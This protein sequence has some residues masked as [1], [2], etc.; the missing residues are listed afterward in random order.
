MYREAYAPSAFISDDYSNLKS[1]YKHPIPLDLPEPVKFYRPQHPPQQTLYEF[2]KLVS[3]GQVFNRDDQLGHYNEQSLVAA[4]DNKNFLPSESVALP[5]EYRE[6]E[7]IV[8]GYSNANIRYKLIPLRKQTA[9][10]NEK[11]NYELYNSLHVPIHRSPYINQLT[12]QAQVNTFPLF[13]NQHSPQYQR[14]QSIPNVSY[15]NRNYTPRKQNL[16]NLKYI[17]APYSRSNV[18]HRKSLPINYAPT[19]AS[20]KKVE[21]IVQKNEDEE[22]ATKETQ[23]I[24]DSTSEKKS[25]G[26]DEGI[27]QDPTYHKHT[28]DFEES[29]HFDYKDPQDR[30]EEEYDEDNKR[31]STTHIPLRKHSNKHSKNDKS[32]VKNYYKFQN[33]NYKREHSKPKSNKSDTKTPKIIYKSINFAKETDETNED[34]I[35]GKHSENIPVTRKHRLFREKLYLS[36][37]IDDVEKE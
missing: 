32:N 3:N 36:K 11:V 24:E 10:G 2:P 23:K 35:E 22:L 8:P 21:N 31:S 30:T 37:N 12:H 9:P 26:E 25:S 33:S 16:N 18:V 29:D 5:I 6:P 27:E 17:P 4:V 34:S 19:K 7:V 13:S 28:F 20:F 14:V 15:I 1:E